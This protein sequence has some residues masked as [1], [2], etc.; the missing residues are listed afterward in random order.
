MY[1]IF[2]FNYLVVMENKE[3]VGIPERASKIYVL[4]GPFE[5]IKLEAQSLEEAS[6]EGIR[7][8]DEMDLKEGFLDQYD[9]EENYRKGTFSK[10]VLLDAK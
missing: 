5:P 8:L 1:K 4:S 10:Q 2:I 6:K 3:S 7:R 9:G